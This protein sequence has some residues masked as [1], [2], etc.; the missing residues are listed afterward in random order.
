MRDFQF[1]WLLNLI[2]YLPLAGALL[3]MFFIKK[4]NTAAIKWFATLITG[5]DFVLAIPLWMLYKPDGAE[6]QFATVEKDA[7]AG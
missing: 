4:E 3:T 5:I 7:F 1:G 2:C 6:F